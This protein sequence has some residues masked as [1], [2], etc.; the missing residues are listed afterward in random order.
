VQKQQRWQGQLLL[1]GLGLGIFLFAKADHLQLCT[2]LLSNRQGG[3][4]IWHVTIHVKN[5]LATHLPLLNS[6]ASDLQ[7]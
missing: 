6:I 7:Y 4:P 2:T 5:T 1:L 3:L